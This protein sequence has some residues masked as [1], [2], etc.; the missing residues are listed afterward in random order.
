MTNQF[1]TYSRNTTD[2]TRILNQ[3]FESGKLS[4]VGISKN[5]KNI[6]Q[7]KIEF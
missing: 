3:I 6:A 2:I 7:D 5:T 4:K 1:E